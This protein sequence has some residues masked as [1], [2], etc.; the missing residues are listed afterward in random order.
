MELKRYAFL[1]KQVEELLANIRELEVLEK[2]EEE[3]TKE[4]IKDQVI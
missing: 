3:E 1:E 4:E 2:L